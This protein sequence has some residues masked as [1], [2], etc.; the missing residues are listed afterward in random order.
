MLT[1]TGLTIAAAGA[2]STAA[3]AKATV[4]A[5]ADCMPLYRLCVYRR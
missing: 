3:G 2:K 4:T 1:A 5:A